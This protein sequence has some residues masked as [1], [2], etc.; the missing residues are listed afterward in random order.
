M[1]IDHAMAT[2]FTYTET[3]ESME[4]SVVQVDSGY[5]LKCCATADC[6]EAMFMPLFC[7][8]KRV[9]TKMESLQAEHWRS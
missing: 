1:R 5:I 9:E 2:E 3:G 6:G 8:C 7:G 4:K